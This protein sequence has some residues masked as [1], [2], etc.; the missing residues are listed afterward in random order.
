MIKSPALLQVSLGDSFF[1]E[2]RF[3]K[4]AEEVQKSIPGETSLRSYNISETPL[5][6]ILMEARS[7]PFLIEHQIFRVREAQLIKN[8]SLGTFESLLKSESLHAAFFFEAAALP[9]DHELRSLAAS[10]GKLLETTEAELESAGSKWVQARLRAAS[11]TMDPPALSALLDRMGDQPSM[12]ESVVDQMINY[13]GS[14]SRIG[15]EV[16]EH[17]SE[18]WQELDSFQ[19]V[20]AIVAKDAGKTVILMRR[21]VDETGQ[22]P[23]ALIGIL[24]WMLRRYWKAAVL[25][26]RGLSQD[27]VFRSCKI[28]PRSAPYFLKQLRTFSRAQWEKAIEGLFD[29]DWKLKTGR[30]EELPGL[31]SWLIRTTSSFSK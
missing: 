19:L 23:Q 25:L 12:L 2:E 6:Q 29:L 14:E 16:V 5:D 18:R 10:Y 11:K 24:H 21:L 9:K 30:A 17:F 27:A 7:L 22:E 4:F 20:N 1:A 15:L 13:V 3:R 26:D 28:S 8:K 31:E